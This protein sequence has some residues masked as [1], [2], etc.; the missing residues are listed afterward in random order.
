MTNTAETTLCSRC[1]NLD[2][3]SYAEVQ[4]RQGRGTIAY[5]EKASIQKHCELCIQFG[6]IFDASKAVRTR[7]SS[8]DS[9]TLDF[10]NV[11]IGD[12]TVVYFRVRFME[13]H[14]VL[15]FDFDFFP[16]KTIIQGVPSAD[17]SFPL[18]RPMGKLS[19]DLG[20]AGQWLQ[21]CRS[22]HYLCRRSQAWT[23]PLR[24]LDCAKSRLLS[25]DS[26]KSYACL[27]YV[28]G[29]QFAQEKPETGGSLQDIPRTIRDAMSVC[30][31]LGIQYLWVDRYCIDQDNVEEKHQLISNMDK[32]YQGAD[33]TII[34]SSGLDPH[35]GLGGV[36]DTPRRP[37]LYLR[38][39]RDTFASTENLREQIKT[40][41]WNSRGWTYQ[42][43]V[44]SRRR[45]FFTDSQMFF[46][47]QCS[48]YLESLSIAAT[49]VPS[50]LA[51]RY[52]ISPP[53]QSGDLQRRI[54]E[55]YPRDLSI[56]SDVLH[57]FTGVCNAVSRRTSANPSVDDFSHFYGI[58]VHRHR[59]KL[60]LQRF[61]QDLSWRVM[62][63][64]LLNEPLTFPPAFPTW[65]W[66]SPKSRHCD[67][68]S[69]GEYVQ[70]L[71][72][73]VS[74]SQLNPRFVTKSGTVLESTVLLQHG[75]GYT[76]FHPHLLLDGTLLTGPFETIMG[77]QAKSG[78]FYIDSH[79]PLD[80][81]HLAA[82]YLGKREP[83]IDDN[84][85][86]SRY[87]THKFVC[88]L[89]HRL[90][91]EAETAYEGLPHIVKSKCYRRV[92]LWMRDVQGDWSLRP[93][94]L[95][96]QLRADSNSLASQDEW[97]WSKQLITL[98]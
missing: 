41:T 18:C 63:S 44:L 20:L 77:G 38:A 95:V 62:H 92:G 91:L 82:L 93:P 59:S 94:D 66:A 19:A 17:A 65:S 11:Q 39:G 2:L 6:H 49:G 72:F 28:W 29:A 43:I 57:A 51:D 37:Q 5:I 55:Y 53:L 64:D 71:N 36:L 8:H 46:E 31:V 85:L 25:I 52:A 42:E 50:P 47:C 45:L 58:P 10:R 15:D 54:A 87:G 74:T 40:S 23:H 73:E 88:L 75:I 48:Q 86:P 68:H 3:G 22:V 70:P 13:F 80:I 9:F 56:S 61:L 1:C 84:M 21:R 69:S 78:S 90:N 35:H 4:R 30:I 96:D 89:V 14:R 60:F 27:S 32:I 67:H 83:A 34:A 97:A 7:L 76:G 24:V 79:E 16:T 98:V 81:K 12:T 33:L 26:S